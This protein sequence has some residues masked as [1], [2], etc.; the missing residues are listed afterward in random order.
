MRAATIGGM[1]VLAS[2]SWSAQ[3]LTYDLAPY[4]LAKANWTAANYLQALI[5]PRFDA[6]A[7]AQ[8][9]FGAADGKGGLYFIDDQ[10]RVIDAFAQ[11]AEFGPVARVEAV[12]AM[13]RGILRARV[14][15]SRGRYFFVI[16]GREA[17]YMKPEGD[18]IGAYWLQDTSTP[19]C[20]ASAWVEGEVG[21]QAAKPSLESWPGVY[22]RAPVMRIDA[23]HPRRMRV[24]VKPVGDYQ[25][26]WLDDAHRVP[27]GED[28]ALRPAGKWLLLESEAHLTRSDKTGWEAPDLW[29][30]LNS[31]LLVAFDPMPETITV[32]GEKGAAREVS[33]TWRATKHVEVRLGSFLEL[34]PADCRFVFRAAEHVARDGHFGCAPYLP[35]RTS[36]GFMGG[37]QG[38]AAAAWMLGEYDDPDAARVKEAALEALRSVI[39]AEERGYHGE[40]AYGAMIAAW[41]LNHCAPGAIDYAKW[42]RVWADREIRRSPPGMLAPPWSDT[43]LR[44]IKGLRY[45]WMITGDEKYRDVHDQA[46]AQWDLPPARPIDA[47]VW[48]GN[49]APFDGYDCTAAAMLLGEWGQAGDARAEAMVREAGERYM[50]DLGFTPLRTWTCDDLLPYYVGYSLPAVFGGAWKGERTN[51]KLGEYAAYDASGAVRRVARPITETPP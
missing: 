37:V 1:L 31:M 43:A 22:D 8:D 12:A 47:F 21:W 7:F 48:R 44:A 41:Y 36:N 18:E 14:P 3:T 30:P 19:F 26:A 40:R 9:V 15:E 33:I 23:D 32:R 17:L 10:G 34:D 2:A 50:C 6:V 27:A 28:R 39:D 5:N 13:A 16:D 25:Y 20:R 49:R 11:E 35:V 29:S 4:D 42:A 46:L 24:R 38:L 45:A 51:L